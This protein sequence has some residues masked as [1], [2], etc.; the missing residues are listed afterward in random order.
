MVMMMKNRK[1]VKMYVSGIFHIIPTHDW[2]ERQKED[3]TRHEERP[4]GYHM[5]NLT[6]NDVYEDKRTTKTKEE[7][8]ICI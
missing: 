3:Y 6:M 8:Y 2:M 1:G 4:P 7:Q 5:D